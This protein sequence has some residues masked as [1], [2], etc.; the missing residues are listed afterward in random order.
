MGAYLVWSKGERA[1][2]LDTYAGL[3][4]NLH[5]TLSKRPFSHTFRS[6]GSTRSSNSTGSKRRH[7]KASGRAK[8]RLGP[9][10]RSAIADRER[11]NGVRCIAALI[12]RSS[13]AVLGVISVSAPASRFSDGDIHG[14]PAERALQRCERHRTI[15]QLLIPC[16]TI[17]ATRPPT[18][19]RVQKLDLLLT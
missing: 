11:L 13:G 19:D 14:E 18:R 5:T 15:H 1:I 16:Y 7:H 6:H 9:S 17:Q 10:T 2:D 8:S 3:R 12:K 4:T